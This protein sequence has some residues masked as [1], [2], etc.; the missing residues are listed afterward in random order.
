[1]ERVV[2]LTEQILATVEDLSRTISNL[3]VRTAS[4]DLALRDYAL[5]ML[6]ELG[7]AR[8]RLLASESE[9]ANLQSQVE[10]LT[11]KL[12][13][14]MT[15]AYEAELQLGKVTGQL[16]HEM[17]RAYEAE[18]GLRAIHASFTWKLGRFFMIPIRVLRRIVR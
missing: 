17:T 18:S 3:S 7:E 4:E 16:A 11:D 9:V 8:A 13:L 2:A 6:A 5:G 1:M 10:S 14:E 12:R 15:R